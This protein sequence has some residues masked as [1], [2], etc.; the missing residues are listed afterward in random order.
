VNKKAYRREV[1][2]M[3]GSEILRGAFL[4]MMEMTIHKNGLLGFK[5]VDGK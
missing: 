3:T 4:F 5:V 2:H 1:I